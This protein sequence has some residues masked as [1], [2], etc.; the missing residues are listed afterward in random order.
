MIH[1]LT[2]SK[3]HTLFRVF[4]ALCFLLSLLAIGC[5]VLQAFNYDLWVDEAFSLHLIQH[6]PMDVIRLTA[7]DVHPPLYYLIL[8]AGITVLHLFVPQASVIVCAKLLSVVPFLALWLIG[9]FW[10]R[11]QW[12]EAVAANFVLLLVGAPQL[13]SYGVDIRMYGWALLFVTSTY[14][15]ALAA[16][17]APTGARAPWIAFVVF[18]LAAAYTHYFSLIAVAIAYLLLLVDAIAFHRER[19]KAILLACVVTALCYLPWLIVLLQ[20]LAA[21]K[22]NYWIGPITWNT[23][24]EYMTFAFGKWRFFLLFLVVW[25]LALVLQPKNRVALSWFVLC[26]AGTIFLGVLVSLVVRPVFVS[27]Y[28]VP[29]LGCLWLAYS[30]GVGQMRHKVLTVCLTLVSVFLCVTSCLS[31]WRAEQEA[32]D[33]SAPL[34]QVLLS[35][36]DDAV[37]IL[38]EARARNVISSMTPSTCYEYTGSIDSL[39]IEVYQNLVPLENISDVETLAQQHTVYIF[40]YEDS[41]STMMADLQ[42]AGW[43]ATK[44]GTYMV[45][46]TVY[47]HPV[48]LY[49]LS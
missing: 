12:N 25:I 46:N 9:L 17:Q 29:T 19:I 13:I 8:Q 1:T 31:F 44:L 21:V 22:E 47:R 41:D 40:T 24:L 38:D 35:Q 32:K 2:E 14:L 43:S 49:R 15:S 48:V 6:S 27:R 42:A 3:K 20:Q 18:S 26:F 30:I 34:M 10:V 39:T 4:Y 5:Q 23:I 36:E 37:Y 33:S 16:R 28:M 7:M 11:K 45:E